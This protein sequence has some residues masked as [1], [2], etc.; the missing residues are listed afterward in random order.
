MEVEGL[1]P[2]RESQLST[3]C[4]PS[5]VVDSMIELVDI[6][7]D[8][9]KHPTGRWSLLQTGKRPRIHP[10]TRR[11]VMDRDNYLCTVCSGNLGGLELDHVRP[12]SIYGPDTSDNLRV[13]CI[14]HNQDRS[15]FLESYLPRI[16]PVTAVCDPC[17]GEHDGLD[18]RGRHG[19]AD[20]LAT[21]DMRCPI[22][23]YGEFEPGEWRIA[24]YCGTCTITSWV[25]DPRRLA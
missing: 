6:L 22:C 25:S 8:M 11:L 16:V 4:G 13:L 3:A 7:E 5:P 19:W 15:N 20:E 18:Y 1:K 2:P 23:W 21:G 24:A 9:G 12:W 10:L 14:D 17:L